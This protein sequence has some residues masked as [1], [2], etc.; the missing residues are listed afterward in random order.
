MDCFQI[1]IL[2]NNFNRLSSFKE[3]IEWFIE[4]GYKNIHVS[5]NCSTYHPLLEYY[6]ELTDRNVAKIHFL[7]EN[8]GNHGFSKIADFQSIQQGW[9]VTTDPD[10]VPTEKT[11]KNL[12]ELLM[13]V[14]NHFGAIKVG[15]ALKIDDIPDFNPHKDSILSW[16]KQFWEKQVSE[17]I[18]EGAIDTTLAL[19]CPQSSGGW[20]GHKTY[21]VAGDCSCR[22]TTWYLDPNNL[23][24]DELN[25]IRSMKRN[26][27]HWSE[28]FC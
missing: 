16:E 25:Y 12:I 26:T 5:D 11:H 20:Q 6:R 7:S 23:P 14:A 8:F 27:S 18:Y 22:H 1:P 4:A 24:D 15:V 17:Y 28:N 13:G 9:F 3:Q 10:V 21:R 19:N 2:I